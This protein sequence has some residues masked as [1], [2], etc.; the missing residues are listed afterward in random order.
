MES[1]FRR[2]RLD[3]Q[4]NKT[5]DMGIQLLVDMYIHHRTTSHRVVLKQLY[6]LLCSVPGEGKRLKLAQGR[7]V[8]ESLA[9]LQAFLKNHD[10][11][12]SPVF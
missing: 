3:S 11:I 7:H 8:R 9:D 4:P 1:A 6:T 10:A 5:R 2:W 12:T